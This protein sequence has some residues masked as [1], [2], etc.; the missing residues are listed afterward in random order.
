MP[1]KKSLITIAMLAIIAILF[2]IQNVVT[3]TTH[4]VSEVFSIFFYSILLYSTVIGS[5]TKAAT[6]YMAHKGISGKKRLIV[7]LCGF[8]LIVTL[9][10]VALFF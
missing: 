7:R 9:L 2:A 5:I 10:L 3:H 8:A 1:G 4:D 6:L